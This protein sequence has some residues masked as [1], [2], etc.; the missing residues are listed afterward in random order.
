MLTKTIASH[1]SPCLLPRPF[2]FRAALLFWPLLLVGLG[3]S[4]GCE[5]SDS[6]TKGKEGGKAGE[7]AKKAEGQKLAKD[8][9]KAYTDK[10]IPVAAA[11]VDRQKVVKTFTSTTFLEPFRQVALEVPSKGVVAKVFKL[12]G[13]DV[14]KG[15]TIAT[16]TSH[17]LMSEYRK[18]SI[19]L[20]NTRRP[21]LADKKLF[22]Q[23]LISKDQWEKSRSAFRSAQVELSRAKKNLDQLKIVAP[24]TGVVAKNELQIHEPIEKIAK[25][26]PIEL[27][28]TAKLKGAIHVPVFYRAAIKVGHK[29]EIA[30]RGLKAAATI[31]RIAPV[32]DRSSG[33]VA[34]H[35]LVPNASQAFFAGESVRVILPLDQGRDKLVLPENSVVFEGSTAFVYTI[36]P[37][38]R[39]EITKEFKAFV[40]R[41]RQGEKAGKGGEQ[42]GKRGRRR[43]G[44]S[45]ALNK[46]AGE[47]STQKAKDDAAKDQPLP[48][49]SDAQLDRMIKVERAKKIAVK[50]EQIPSGRYA[51]AD[52]SSAVKAGQDVVII[53][54]TQIDD[55]R[56]IEIVP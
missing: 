12:A 45:A 37:S 19:T 8:F 2:R 18:R 34:M 9:V 55:G 39:K 25:N 22:D 31:E 48:E 14:T 1:P 7:Q 20:A 43:R 47:S 35:F 27:V 30:A 40:K 51:L 10:L 53:G 44:G 29:L 49:L 33:T 28:D 11:K 21:Y 38:E 54:L 15:E 24:F 50:V 36:R 23:Q 3:L 41:K 56:K 5:S 26:P 52:N 17:D 46:S 32:V 16:L 13:Q 42:G 4:T 6:S